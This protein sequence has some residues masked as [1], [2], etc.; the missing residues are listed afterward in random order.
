M[1]NIRFVEVRDHDLTFHMT[2][3][4]FTAKGA[5]RDVVEELRGE[6]FFRCN[7]GYLVNLAFVDGVSGYDVQV[8][9]DM[10]TVATLTKRSLW[11]P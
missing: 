2:D 5:I 7:K 6:G 8:G 11:T 10:I 9:K 1:Q 4:D 3:G